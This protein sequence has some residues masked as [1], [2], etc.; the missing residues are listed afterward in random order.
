MSDNVSPVKG[1]RDML[2]MFIERPS[3]YHVE[4]K[5]CSGFW[6]DALSLRLVGRLEG[7]WSWDLRVLWKHHILGLLR[8]RGGEN[9][10]LLALQEYTFSPQKSFELLFQPV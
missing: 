6:D 10:C 8:G 4:S 9:T 1:L 2:H 5:G 7:S 3:I